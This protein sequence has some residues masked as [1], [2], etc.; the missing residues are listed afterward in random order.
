MWTYCGDKG[1][2]FFTGSEGQY[3]Y[4]IPGKD[5]VFYIHQINESQTARVVALV[6]KIRH[7]MN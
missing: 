7:I 6:Q 1:L 4:M 2:F 5:L 3:L